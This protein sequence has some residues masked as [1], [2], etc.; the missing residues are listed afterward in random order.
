MTSAGR[1]EMVVFAIIDGSNTFQWCVP[2]SSRHS[3]ATCAHIHL[4]IPFGGRF[5]PQGNVLPFAQAFKCEALTLEELAERIAKDDHIKPSDNKPPGAP[6]TP[7]E[8][9]DGTV[10]AS[11]RGKRRRRA[12]GKG[13]TKMRP[14]ANDKHRGHSSEEDP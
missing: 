13:N 1:F 12:V 14:Q 5:N 8:S 9:V 2:S 4:F 6:P 3:H 11:E 7:V 10:L